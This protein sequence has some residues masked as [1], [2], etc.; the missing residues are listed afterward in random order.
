MTGP[1]ATR[2]GRY[3]S[4]ALLAA[5]AIATIWGG[6]LVVE[7]APARFLGLRLS[8]R[9]PNALLMGG[10]AT[11]LVCAWFRRTTLAVLTDRHA[12]RA[13]A[14]LAIVIV[15][16]ALQW[17]AKVAG[18]ADAYGYLTEAGLIREGQLVVHQDVVR[19][20]PWP[21]AG[22]TWS[23]IGYRELPRERDAI[24]PVYAPGFPLLIALLQA[25][26]GF[27]AAFWVVPICAGATIW[28]TYALGQRVFGRPDVALWGAVLLA[29]SPTFLFQSLA[30][31]SDV[32]VTAAWTLAILLCLAE[33]P[34]GAGLIAAVAIAI[35]PNLAPAAL[36]LLLWT[37]LRDIERRG[38]PGWFGAS[39]IRMAIGLA[40]AVIGIAWVN[41]RLYGSPLESGYGQLED[42][43]SL[44]YLW[45]NVAQFSTW[46]GETDTPVV[47][48]AAVFFVS[49]RLLPPA[50]I[51][52]PR[53]LLGAFTAIIILSYLFYLPFDAWWFLRFLLPAWP[54][55]M[56]LTAGALDAI[57]RR[58]MASVHR[59]A[60]TMIVA[61]L[62]CHGVGLSIA[63]GG[64]TLWRDESRYIDV[65]R[66]INASTDPR[67]VFLSW[68]HSASI[69]FY[70]DRLTLHFARLDRR[71]LDRAVAHLQSSGRKPYIVLDGFEVERFR[72]RFSADN[73][74][75]ALD[76]T[77]M[78]V[79]ESPTVVIYD[80]AG[81]TAA[82]TPMR[83]PSS[84]GQ[85]ARECARPPVWPP[86]LRLD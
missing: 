72:Q 50:R 17:G 56:V 7:G 65:G 63:R 37:L 4:N 84:E 21:G 86:R 55:V 16:T 25:L 39:T 30:Q 71:W 18:G 48:L 36:A 76:W 68:Q 67:A 35:R 13:A 8:S 83:I 33:R 41:A 62:A 85:S 79:F 70:G 22:G 14:V 1:G 5:A 58:W 20:S 43:Y 19:E 15:L 64:F 26:F 32:P 74:L 38:S 23:P 57:A 29:A 49:P 2:T 24:T 3:A 53:V 81:Q 60:V 77:P 27:C 47:A 45:R 12:P 11:L 51:P 75:G 61:L 40:P 59:G 34:F 10:V 73:R 69:R 31:M 78:A 80:P 66:F 46:I 44:R 82:R 52:F 28:L 9:Y 42:L 6:L 54:I